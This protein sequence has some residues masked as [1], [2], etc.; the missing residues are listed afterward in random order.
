MSNMSPYQ[1]AIKNVM[2]HIKSDQNRKM[3]ETEPDKVINVFN[4]SPVLSI[5]F[6]KPLEKVT[7][8]MLMFAFNDAWQSLK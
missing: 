1:F 7:E 2:E 5:A 3:L 8:D 6:M 4:A